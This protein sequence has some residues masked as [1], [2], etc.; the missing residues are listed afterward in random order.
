MAMMMVMMIIG[1]LAIIPA[2]VYTGIDGCCIDRPKRCRSFATFC[3]PRL[4][5]RG[6][7][8]AGDGIWERGDYRTIGMCAKTSI[9]VASR[10]GQFGIVE[11]NFRLPLIIVLQGFSFGSYQAFLRLS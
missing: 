5:R 1:M 8:Q 6:R 3:W 7:G 10:I 9:A 11:H 2:A 4:M